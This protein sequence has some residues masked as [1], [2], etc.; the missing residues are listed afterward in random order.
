[1]SGFIGLS[2]EVIYQRAFS[3]INGDLYTTYAL[4]VLTFIIAMAVGNLS[5]F[6]LRRFLFALELLGGGFTLVF[7]LWLAEGNLYTLYLPNIV[8][9]AILAVPAFII[10]AHVPLYAYY[11]RERDFNLIY[12]I[13]HLGAVVSMLLLEVLI[14]PRLPLS[15]VFIFLG[16]LQLLIGLLLVMAYR[17][18]LFK[19]S[20]YHFSS[21]TL[22]IFVCQNWHYLLGVA[23]MSV[24]SYFFHFMIIRLLLFYQF[25]VRPVYAYFLIISIFYLT[26]GAYLSSKKSYSLTKIIFAFT[27]N[28]FLVIYVLANLTPLIANLPFTHL[29]IYFLLLD[30]LALS[31]LL[32]STMFFCRVVSQICRQKQLI[33]LHSGVLLAISSIGNLLGFF[34]SAILSN[35]LGNYSWLL[36]ILTATIFLL[37]FIVE[38]TSKTNLLVL[39]LILI[40]FGGYQLA[41]YNP[42]SLLSEALRIKKFVQRQVSGGKPQVIAGNSLDTY[43]KFSKHYHYQ[44]KDLASNHHSLVGT[45]EQITPASG[46][47]HL[48][49]VIDGYLSHLL[50]TYCETLVGLLPQI[51]FPE[52]LTKSLVIGIGTGQTVSG[53]AMISKQTTAVDIS[54]AV[55]AF[56]SKLSAYNHDLVNNPTVELVHSDGMNYLKRD[57]GNYQLILNTATNMFTHGVAKLHT[58]EFLDLVSKHLIADG[59][60]VSWLDSAGVKSHA[61]LGQIIGLHRKYFNYIDAYFLNSGYVLLVSYQTKRD[62]RPLNAELLNATD[63]AYLA[64]QGFS[65]KQLDSV[66]NI[67]LKTS[68][69]TKAPLE[70]SKMD[71]PKIE[72]NALESYLSN[73]GDDDFYLDDQLISQSLLID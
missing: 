11:L 26:L 45:F 1:M 36:L 73:A 48:V 40:I 41:N 51:Y 30:L 3:L 56:L 16:S 37:W 54:P 55:F 4:I 65:W 46:S 43:A 53:T 13:Y 31:P 21:N 34:L 22:K 44:L 50:D 61:Q 20:D 6:F 23:L 15:W 2:Y 60:Y 27:L 7:G 57:S 67:S 69:K 14:F 38:E 70:L 63:Q 42:D 35:W 47:A 19:I 58:V 71:Y 24:M 39:S 8:L 9:I 68:A 52:K 12:F 5:G 62:L 32:F 10:G 72:I 25:L 64:D 66:L 17:K 33:D 29:N 49:Y 59:V 18:Q 28:I